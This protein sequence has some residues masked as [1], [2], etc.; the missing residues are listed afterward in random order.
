VKTAVI[1]ARPPHQSSRAHHPP[2][3][4]G[5]SVAD[6]QETRRQDRCV[7]SRKAKRPASELSSPRARPL[8]K[9]DTV[10]ADAGISAE[11]CRPRSGAASGTPCSRSARRGLGTLAL[12][13]SRTSARRGTL[14]PSRMK[15]LTIK[16]IEPQAACEQHSQRMLE[17]QAEDSNRD[18]GDDDQPCH[19]SVGVSMRC[20]RTVAKNAG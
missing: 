4:S 20:L 9:C 3:P 8:A 10:T 6:L 12:T 18:R 19:R 2:P 1:A 7:A 15:P 13:S 14:R 11:D 16:K 5:R 17:Q